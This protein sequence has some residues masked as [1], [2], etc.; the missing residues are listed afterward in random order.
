[1]NET[2]ESLVTA[3]RLRVEFRGDTNA[4]TI[5]GYAIVYDRLSEDLGGFREKVS[6]DAVTRALERSGDIRALWSHDRSLV[7]G[8]TVSGSL[9]LQADDHGLRTEIDP[10]ATTFGRDALESIRRGDVDGMSFAFRTFGESWDWNA[11]PPVR[12]LDDIE[13]LEVSP[14][15]FPAYKATSVSARALEQV[16]DFLTM[17]ARARAREE[18]D[19]R[20]ARHQRDLADL[21]GSM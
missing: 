8:R 2:R 3:S 14:V 7:L 21:R 6:R 20:L 15:A 9:R 12:T 16:R 13:I 18:H 17:A 11:D 10:P 1:M 19:A 5:V 4:P